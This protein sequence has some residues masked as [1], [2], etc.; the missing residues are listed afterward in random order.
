MEKIVYVCCGFVFKGIFSRYYLYTIQFTHYNCTVQSFQQLAKY[1]LHNITVKNLHIKLYVFMIFQSFQY[2]Y[3]L[4]NGQNKIKHILKYL[5]FFVVKTKSS[6]LS[7]EHQNFFFL[8][9]KFPLSQNLVIYN[10]VGFQVC[11]YLKERCSVTK[12]KR[13]LMAEK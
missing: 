1:H 7:I 11:N 2:M 6:Y 9:T 8:L 3:T 12:W 4:C 10:I 13:Q 5:S